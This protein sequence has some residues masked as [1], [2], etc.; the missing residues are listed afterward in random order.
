MS[1]AQNRDD[2]R[3]AVGITFQTFFLKD[4]LLLVHSPHGE[5]LTVTVRPFSQSKAPR[6]LE[7]TAAS[8]G[9]VL[10]HGEECFVLGRAQL[11]DLIEEKGLSEV[12]EAEELLSGRERVL[13]TPLGAVGGLWS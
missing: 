6:Q 13:E 10:V 12:R 2:L 8:D 1:V 11:H 9:E 7:H 3:I 5:G 4:T